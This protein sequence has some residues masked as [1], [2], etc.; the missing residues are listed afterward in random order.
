MAP[1]KFAAV[2][3]EFRLRAAQ[4]GKRDARKFGVPG[5]ARE[6]RAGA[7][8][9]LGED[10]RRTGGTRRPQH[11]LDI[12]GDRDAAAA[13]RVV[14]HAQ[15]ADLDG[16]LERHE[17]RELQ[18][19]AMGQVLEAAVA[20]AVRAG[21]LRVLETNRRGRGRPQ[22]AAFLVAHVDSLARAIGDR[23]VR[24]GRQR[25]L[26][27][28]ARPGVPATVAR[29]LETEIAIRHDVDPRQRRVLPIGRRDAVFAALR[30]EAA[31]AV[32]EFQPARVLRIGH[33]RA[34]HRRT[35]R[36]SRC[37]GRYRLHALHLFGEAAAFARQLDAR[38][39]PQQRARFRR[40]EVGAQHEHF[41]TRVRAGDARAREAGAHRRLDGHLQIL[42]IRSAAFV[43]DHQVHRQALD[44]PVFVGLQEL[45]DRHEVVHVI[46]PQQH[47]GQITGDGL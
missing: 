23:I 11:P 15:P 19:D 32:E 10:V 16:I 42:D 40:D 35:S 12:G 45:A 46:D 47:D 33:R 2:A 6:Q 38:H 3:G 28:V 37:G 34:A 20:H 13:R 41:A 21:V 1:E 22:F 36:K 30:G 7:G 5:I 4:V 39:G 14:A 29:D 18:F 8:V 31:D 17:H 43:E 9:P 26:A 44:S 24:P 25:V 27:T